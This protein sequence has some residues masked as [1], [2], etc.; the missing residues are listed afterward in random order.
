MK[1]FFLH[2]LLPILVLVLIV[3]LFFNDVSLKDIKTNFLKIPL[4]YLL[5][6]ALLTLAGTVLRA[7]KYHILLSGKL[8]FKDIFLIPLVRNFSVD[9][10]PGRAAALAFYS[11]LTRKKGITWEE[12]ASSFMV[13]AFYDA[14]ALSF[15]LSGLLFF[16]ETSSA[17]GFIYL[18]MTVIFLLSVTAVFLSD[19]ITGLVLRKQWFSRFP[20]VETV[21]RNIDAYLKQHKS[22]GHRL[23][24]F[25]LSLAARIV[26]YL[27]V[28]I[29]FEGMMHLGVGLRQFSLFSFGLAGTELSALFPIQG[30]GGFG[31][32]E[33]TFSMVF[34][35]LV[36]AENIKEA[37]IVIHITTQVWEYSIGLAALAY[38]F[39]GS[40]R[41]E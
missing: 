39:F 6:F 38:L 15:M 10:L 35:A 30:P 4:S 36:N 22:P 37:G 27:F 31:T 23:Q 7:L 13:S 17:R 29:L 34:G 5:L 2:I 18:G 41:S 40:R 9:L 26:K 3:V 20:K 12:G 24:L 25:L 32:W 14:L 28:F 16:L 1:K 19:W 11:W 21:I 33:L 8:L